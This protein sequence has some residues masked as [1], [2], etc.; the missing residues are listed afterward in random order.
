MKKIIFSISLLLVGLLCSAKVITESQ[1]ASYA[2][3]FFRTSTPVKLVVNSEQIACE[4]A[5]EAPLYYVFNNPAGGW[6]MISGEDTSL[7]V[8]AYS[9]TG[10]F[11]VKGM[12]ENIKY[13][14]NS[15]RSDM[16]TLRSYNLARNERIEKAWNTI[17]EFDRNA[18]RKAA[19]TIESA[20]WNQSAP[21]NKYAPVAGS[22]AGC[23]ATAMSIVMRQNKWPEKG[24]G[25]IPAYSSKGTLVPARNIEGKVYEWDKMPL[26]DAIKGGWDDDTIDKVA[27]LMFDCGCMVQMSYTTSGSGAYSEIVAQALS[28]YM[29]YSKSANYQQRCLYTTDEWLNKIANELSNGRLVYYSGSGSGGHAFV[30]DGVNIGA[31]DAKYLRIN[32]GWSG[33]DN[34]WFTLDLYISSSYQ[35]GVGQD[36]IFDLIP[37]QSGTSQDAKPEVVLVAYGGMYGLKLVNGE[38]VKNKSFQIEAGYFEN[39]NTAV[40]YDG[41]LT[42]ALFDRNGKVREDLPSSGV[43][44]TLGGGNMTTKT[45]QKTITTDINVTDY[46]AIMHKVNGYTNWELVRCDKETPEFMGSLGVT[47]ARIILYDEN[48]KAGDKLPLKLS[49]GQKGTKSVSWK[50]NGNSVKSEATLVSGRNEIIA[51]ITY[52][53]GST[54]VANLILDL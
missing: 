42:C 51:N 17:G 54:E 52:A 2:Q 7:P 36:A 34:G 25:T 20:Q 4:N 47:D 24:K 32:W 44:L 37:D 30:C 48:V 1:A 46:L 6:V 10:S 3:K 29:R 27:S 53:D 23:V 45:I 50:V 31:G 12:P 26:T 14:M 11:E 28:T 18:S 8:L 16:K 35:F 41:N 19:K 9:N 40:K 39:Q 13:F 33:S 5:Y 38:V 21:Y 43:E 22:P 15:Y 49:P